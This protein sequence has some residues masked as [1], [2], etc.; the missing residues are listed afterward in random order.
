M[1]KAF[2]G[3]TSTFARQPSTTGSRHAETGADAEHRCARGRNGFVDTV[4]P[5]CQRATPPGE[6]EESEAICS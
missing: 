3:A 1:F 4:A 5:I 6:E 2:G